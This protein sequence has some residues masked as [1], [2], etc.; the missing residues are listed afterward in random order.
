MS[1]RRRSLLPGLALI[2]LCACQTQPRTGHEL[3][4]Q[5]LE[6]E[7]Y[8]LTNAMRAEQGLAPLAELAELDGLSRI[9]SENMAHNDFFDHKDPQGLLPPERMLKFLPLLLSAN[10]GENIALRSIDADESAMA[11]TLMSLWR[12][13]PEHYHNII[14]KAFRHMGV[15]AAT[16]DDKLY[17]TQTFASAVALL[18]AQPQAVFYG[19]P[20]TLRFRFL[21]DFP[22]SE[23][24]AFLH[25]PDPEARIPA[26][27]GTA[28]VGKGPLKPEWTDTEHFQ[29]SLP[30]SYGLGTYRIRIG[31]NGTYYDKDFSFTAVKN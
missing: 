1:L 30:A 3:N 7:I 31:H 4:L 19:S 2:L 5:L 29:L 12:N 17:A 6:S 22:T 26:G 11:Q 16:Q 8:R 20:V 25:A 23:L 13:S 24:T 18:E 21:A 10:S 9:H 15:G 27:N 28:F 14:N